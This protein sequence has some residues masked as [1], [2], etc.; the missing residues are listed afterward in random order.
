MTD[1]CAEYSVKYI[2]IGADYRTFLVTAG[3]EFHV[4]GFSLMV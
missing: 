4:G 2:S 3:D 1:P